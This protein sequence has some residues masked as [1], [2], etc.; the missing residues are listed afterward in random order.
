[1]D[2]KKLRIALVAPLHDTVP[3]KKYGGTERVLYFLAEELISLGHSVTLYGAG[4]SLTSA[5]FVEC[6]PGTFR[7]TGVGYDEDNVEGADTAQLFRVFSNLSSYDVVHIHHGTYPFHAAIFKNMDPGPFIWTEHGQVHVEDKPSIL[8]ALTACNIGMIAISQSQKDSLPDI[9]WLG[10]VHNGIPASLFTTI[11]PANPPAS[12][13]GYVAFLGRITPDKGI[14]PAV[15][16][17]AAAGLKLRVAA[18]IDN[19]FEGFYESSVKPLFERFAVD[20]MGEIT[21]DQKGAFL[22][23][24]IALIFSTECLEPFGLVMIEAMACGTPVVAYD[25]GAVREILEHGK[26][27]FIVDTEAEAVESLRRVPSLDRMQIRKTFEQ[28]F[29]SRNMAQNYVQIYKR[30]AEGAQKTIVTNRS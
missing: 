7:E 21:D 12:A 1:M 27:G 19:I 16:I 6:W 26:T 28:R 8:S 29:T 25:R 3:P 14:I 22:G 5:Q 11:P 4:G 13:S 20:F 23:N 24:A 17:A 30:F 18:K 9:N 2:A 15:Q 10:V